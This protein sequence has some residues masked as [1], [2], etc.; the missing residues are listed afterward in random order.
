MSGGKYLFET[1]SFRSRFDLIVICLVIGF[2]GKISF[3]RR[4]KKREAK[5][6]ENEKQTQ[7]IKELNIPIRRDEI[8]T[9]NN[10][11]SAHLIEY[12]GFI[13]FNEYTIGQE[14][15]GASMN[16]EFHKQ[17]KIQNE[18]IG[19]F[20]YD[21]ILKFLNDKKLPILETIFKGD[22]SWDKKENHI[23]FSNISFQN[24]SNGSF[25]FDL[26]SK[27]GFANLE[28]VSARTT[29]LNRPIVNVVIPIF[30]KL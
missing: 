6:K 4:K 16:E 15:Y 8:T 2:A 23:N 13:E 18:D 12:F 11:V 10:K 22:F 1:P 25:N 19:K 20:S 5:Q 17:I 27:K 7:E 14:V 29:F 24:I 9:A 28:S 26:V 21:L 3:D 30:K